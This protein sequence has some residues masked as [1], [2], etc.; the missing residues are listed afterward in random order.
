MPFVEE[1][2]HVSHE[3][4]ILGFSLYVV[5]IVF[6]STLGAPLSEL[7]GRRPVYL[8]SLPLLMG[9]TTAV[10]AAKNIE[11]ILVCRFLGG[12]GGSAAVSVGGGE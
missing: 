8:A 5:G 6:G 4:A 11:T 7:F 1:E 10:A 2:F 12:M 3:V 9:F